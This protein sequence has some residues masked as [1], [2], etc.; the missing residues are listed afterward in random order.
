[1]E[2]ANLLEKL[3]KEILSIYDFI[4]FII[5]FG[6]KGSHIHIRGHL[7]HKGYHISIRGQQ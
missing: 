2:K 1:M 4:D 7:P 5:L 6:S 3:K